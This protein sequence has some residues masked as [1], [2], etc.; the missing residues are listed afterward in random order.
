M[1]ILEEPIKKCYVI[2]NYIDGE[3]VESKELIDVINPATG[4][5]LAQVPISLKEELDSAIEAA[6]KAFPQWRRTPPLAR[7]RCLLR[8]R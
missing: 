4:K 8:L 5:K 6:K 7:A 2:K 1:S 3:W